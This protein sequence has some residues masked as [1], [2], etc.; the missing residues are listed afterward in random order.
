MRNTFPISKYR[1]LHPEKIMKQMCFSFMLM[2]QNSDMRM[3]R[4]CTTLLLRTERET[5][6][7]I[8]APVISNRGSN[9]FK[10]L[11]MIL[12]IIFIY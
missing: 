3:Y 5:V 4:H 7:M 1:L 8:A 9:P 2:D 11:I 12:L 10:K 6:K